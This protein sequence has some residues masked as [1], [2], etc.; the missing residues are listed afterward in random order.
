[1][2]QEKLLG[3]RKKYKINQQELADLIGVST[4]TYSDKEQGKI[5]FK[6]TEMF[7]IADYFKLPIEDVFLPRILQNGVEGE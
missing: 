1:M 2:F 3:L 7:Q 4:K 6:C 5:Q